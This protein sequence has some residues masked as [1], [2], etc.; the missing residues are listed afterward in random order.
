[1]R[2]T[3]KL[4]R[5]PSHRLDS[6][7][8]RS[9][10]VFKMGTENGAEVL[11]FGESAGKLE[12]GRQADIVLLDLGRICEPFMYAGHHPLDMLLY[13]G[14]ARDVRTVLVGGEIL[15]KNGKLTQIDREEVIRK[16]RESIPADYEDQF[17]K[18]NTLFPQLRAAIATQCEQSYEEIEEWEK[19]PYYFLNNRF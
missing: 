12:K 9:G 8:L 14:Q 19:N 18:A 1:M 4:H 5:L 17:T 13:R 2:L 15:L 6:D 7:H 11:G 3:A 10:E 16:L